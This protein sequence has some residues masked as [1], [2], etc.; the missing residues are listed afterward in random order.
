[1]KSALLCVGD[2]ILNGVILNTNSRHLNSFMHQKGW[3]V[4]E[5]RVVK[6]SIDDIAESVAELIGK[7]NLL[8]VTG[9]LGPTF[10]DKTVD[11][12]A[13]ALKR[14]V[15]ESRKMRTRAK[16]HMKNKNEL[17]LARQSRMVEKAVLIDN[18]AGI[19]MCQK[20]SVQGC[21]IYLLPG[22]PS[23]VEWIVT[24]K[25]N[26]EIPSADFKEYKLRLF[27]ATETAVHIKLCEKFGEDKTGAV[28]FLPSTGSLLLITA[29]KN[30]ILHARKAFPENYALSGDKPIERMLLEE[31]KRRN[32]SLA[33]AES[34]T[35]G[36]ISSLITSVE[37]SSKVFKGCAVV[38]SNEAKEK[39]L[40]I[41]KRI[42]D[43]YGAVSRE[44]AERMAERVCSIFK[45]DASIAVTGIAGPG[46]GSNNKPVGLV[47]ISTN[48]K[49]RVVTLER[50]FS[51]G[52]NS[53]KMK[54]SV[55]ALF[56]LLR[57][58]INE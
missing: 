54:S 34:C 1:M 32:L 16:K 40:G 11:G 47:Y 31:M 21:D 3:Q 52:R 42:I 29:D 33:L 41:N 45:T 22:V 58:V 56:N 8:L 5:E 4:I 57:R 50:K 43:R 49:N 17:L 25:L 46:G 37:G 36:A 55:I 44:T 48:Y 38:Y 23:E 13:K 10:D 12:V 14:R 18:S 26:K 53:V 15:V 7:C 6:D 19:A 2:E 24:N 35:G 30:I 28:S 9:G 27:D 51:G 20:L 39:I